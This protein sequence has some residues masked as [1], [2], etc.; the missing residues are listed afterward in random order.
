VAKLPAATIPRA[1]QLQ[2]TAGLLKAV[3]DTQ[4]NQLLGCT[5]FCA[6]SSEVINTVAMA[7]STKLDYRVVRDTIF[8]HPSMSETLNDLLSQVN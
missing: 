5:L 6:D 4:T 1:Q 8:T 3:I 2:E 7:M